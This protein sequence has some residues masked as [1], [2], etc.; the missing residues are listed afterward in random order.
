MLILELSDSL[1]ETQGFFIDHK[2]IKA[3]KKETTWCLQEYLSSLRYFCPDVDSDFCTSLIHLSSQY[4]CETQRSFYR[5][6]AVLQNRELK[7]WRESKHDSRRFLQELSCPG[8]CDLLLP[9]L[10]LAICS[11][12]MALSTGLCDMQGLTG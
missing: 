8:S 4:A 9:W 6:S 7:H 10:P 11:C 2:S 5:N 3:S 12:P 1:C